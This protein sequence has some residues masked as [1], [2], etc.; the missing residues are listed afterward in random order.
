M[1][2]ELRTGLEVTVLAVIDLLLTESI[3]LF[4]VTGSIYVAAWVNSLSGHCKF[5]PNPRFVPYTSCKSS[6]F[7]S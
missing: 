7:M 6:K 3:V 1:K 4:Y 2:T 5:S